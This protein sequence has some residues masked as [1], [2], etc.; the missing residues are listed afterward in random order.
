MQLSYYDLHD[1]S[2][3]VLTTSTLG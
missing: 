3:T 1:L 2:F